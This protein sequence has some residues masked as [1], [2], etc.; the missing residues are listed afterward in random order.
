[1]SRRWLLPVSIAGAL[2]LIFCWHAALGERSLHDAGLRALLDAAFALVLA[3]IV[4]LLAAG[5]GQ[6]VL[7][8][9][10]GE[11]NLFDR[12]LWSV[13]LGLGLLAYGVLLLG[14]LGWLS[15]AAFA[16]WLLLAGWWSRREW[17]NWLGECRSAST[18]APM[19]WRSLGRFHRWLLLAGGLLVML[20]LLQALT[21]P[22]DYDGLMYHL[23]GPRL[24]LEAGRITL[25]PDIWQANGPAALDMLFMLGLGLGSDTFARL[26]HL[27]CGV[28]LVLAT[29][30][31]G[32]RYIR[33]GGGWLA[34][35]ILIGMPI[36]FMWASWAYTDMA[37]ALFEFLGIYA[38][39][40]WRD[41]K[42]R[43]GLLLGA[44]LLGLAL[45]SKYLALST[46][47]FLGFWVFWCSRS[48]GWRAVVKNGVIYGGVVLLIGSPWYLKNG[49]LAGNP[50]YPLIW[51]GAQWDQE[52]VAALTA[53]LYSFSNGRTAL[54]Y[55]RLPFDVYFQRANFTGLMGGIEW[56]SWLFPLAVLAP[57]VQRTRQITTLGVITL[58]QLLVWVLGS[59]QLRFLLP[60]LP[61]LS[62]LTA[63]VIVAGLQHHSLPPWVKR[64][65]Q[66]A[67][68]LTVGLA[69]VI[70]VLFM[71]VSRPWAVIVGAESK[72]AFLRR[73]GG[74]YAAQQ[75]IQQL[76]PS[77]RALLMWDGRS[78]Y[79][80]GR[81]VPDTAQSQWTILFE[82]SS[83]PTALAAQL[84]ER[85][86]THLLYSPGDARFVA[87]RDVTG[88]NQAALDFFR[89]QFVPA[90]ARAVYQDA[91][92]VVYKLLRCHELHSPQTMKSLKFSSPR[93]GTE[94]IF[95]S[96][97]SQ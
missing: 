77:A 35:G 92:A 65:L 45:G 23:Q 24:F 46:A 33:S 89:K 57:F 97:H 31:F 38:L 49:W 9:L 8:G 42:Q 67:V 21:P 69:V 6:R 41:Q 27:S 81:C 94:S 93:T 62:L 28:L 13:P 55:L 15:P 73:Q 52:R 56:L 54:D 78:Y 5:L 63:T 17:M 68:G 88:R 90:C 36:F 60:A 80:G 64:L 79:C 71:T 50:L 37:W 32:Q 91:E 82:R 12:T 30:S 3:S 85:G 2:A 95:R 19:R 47:A 72:D 16:A 59:Q 86:I 4:L 61:G 34:A 26:I 18:S 39:I 84:H 25:L 1:M 53:F 74:S 48:D 40:I 20:A 70:A 66:G 58:F 75:F 29:F 11:R 44:A 51:G 43:A 14:L 96:V 10:I 7:K 22:Y 87:Q 83:G 76:E